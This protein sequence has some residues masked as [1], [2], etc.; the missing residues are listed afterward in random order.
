MGVADFQVV[1]VVA[2]LIV[3]ESV[4]AGM[5]TACRRSIAVGFFRPVVATGGVGTAVFWMVAPGCGSTMNDCR[6]CAIVA[7]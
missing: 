4:V 5:D 6:G 7:L 2:R 3:V 1:V